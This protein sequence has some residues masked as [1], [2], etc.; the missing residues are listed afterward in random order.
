LAN[1]GTG[2]V[3]LHY[4]WMRDSLAW[5]VGLGIVALLSTLGAELAAQHSIAHNRI[6]A[7]TV[8]FLSAFGVY[9]GL[10]FIVSMIFRSGVADYTPRL[11]GGSSPSMP[12]SSLGSL[13]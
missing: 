13:R 5:G 2:F 8:A 1:Q 3:V 9:E 10:L 12:S 4:P 6:V 11:S 7:S